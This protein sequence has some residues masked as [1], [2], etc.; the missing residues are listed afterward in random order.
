MGIDAA[1]YQK[2]WE[3][4]YTVSPGPCCGCGSGGLK[5]G[6]GRCVCVG[7][8]EIPNTRRPPCPLDCPIALSPN[9]TIS[10][11]KPAHIMIYAGAAPLRG[12]HV[13]GRGPEEVLVGG[14]LGPRDQRLSP[15]RCVPFLCEIDWELCVVLIRG[16][17]PKR[18]WARPRS[19]AKWIVVCFIAVWTCT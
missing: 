10:N 13:P 2:N 9:H 8:S 4:I 18:W 17:G 3:T 16:S 6:L 1:S 12:L 14:L 11:N 5:P 15:P 7:T 19:S